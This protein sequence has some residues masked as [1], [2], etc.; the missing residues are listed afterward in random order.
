MLPFAVNCTPPAADGSKFS[1]SGAPVASV[2]LTVTTPPSQPCW[3][4]TVT[5]NG[6]AGVSWRVIEIPSSTSIGTVLCGTITAPEIGS[7]ASAYCEV[8]IRLSQ[9]RAVMRALKTLLRS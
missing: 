2:P 3:K 6:F 5:M 4:V 9:R 8:S 1:E 7:L